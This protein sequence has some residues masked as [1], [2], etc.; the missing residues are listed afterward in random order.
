MN[1]NDLN[2]PRL[3]I[4]W[5]GVQSAFDWFYRLFK[6][7]TIYRFIIFQFRFECFRFWVGII[8]LYVSMYV[9]DVSSQSNQSTKLREKKIIRIKRFFNSDERIEF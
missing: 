9:R 2:L 3:R 8:H 4:S 1:K 6:S 5:I 7:P